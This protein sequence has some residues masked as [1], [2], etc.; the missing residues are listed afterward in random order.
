[1]KERRTGRRPRRRHRHR[2]AAQA[3]RRRRGPQPRG[4]RR[5]RRRRGVPH[6]RRRTSARRRRRPPRGAATGSTV[7][8]CGSCG[9]RRRRSWRLA[10]RVDRAG[11]AVLTAA[12]T[13]RLGELVA[14][15]AAGDQLRAGHLGSG[16]SRRSIPSPPSNCPPR[17]R[18]RRRPGHDDGARAE[19]ETGQGDQGGIAGG[20]RPCRSKCQGA[21]EASAARGSR[22]QGGAGPG[23]GRAAR[24]RL[25]EAAR[26]GPRRGH[27]G[28]GAVAGTARGV[29]SG[30][31]GPRHGLGATDA[32]RGRRRRRPSRPRRVR[33]GLRPSGLA[34]DGTGKGRHRNGGAMS[35]EA[36]PGVLVDLDGTLV[37][38]NYLHT[39]A[40]SRA[41][42]DAGEWA[43]DGRHSPPHRHGERPAPPGAAGPRQPRRGRCPRPAAT[44]ELMGEARVLPDA[45]PM[46]WRPW[47]RERPG[48]RDRQLVASRRAGRHADPARRRR[49]HR[50]R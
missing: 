23:D 13:A 2:R 38:T 11:L 44:G 46:P 33:L 39:L 35:N 49:R 37:D 6:R 22:G 42:S 1:M 19:G 31:I 24:R 27:R 48:R 16:A 41:L 21:G 30:Y 43:P 5:A 10:A 3:E 7:T 50:R 4:R 40:W 14:N 26:G 47:H 29:G 25:S 9:R 34:G 28:R 15:D 32:R 36:R 45:P 20:R 8:R 18:R 12:A 17:R